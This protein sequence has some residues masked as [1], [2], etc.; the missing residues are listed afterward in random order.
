MAGKGN[1]GVAVSSSSVKIRVAVMR[2]VKRILLPLFR[3]ASDLQRSTRTTL[4]TCN[5]PTSTDYIM[6]CS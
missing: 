1:K 2:R 4:R 3:L 5:V 6:N